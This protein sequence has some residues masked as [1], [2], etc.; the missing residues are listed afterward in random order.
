MRISWNWLRRYADT[1]LTPQQ[2][3]EVLTSTGLETE[4]VETFEPVKGMLEGVVVGHVLQ[5]DQHPDADRLSL[6]TV[7]LGEESSVQIVCGAPNVAAGQ[8]VLVATI[9]T[10]LHFKD[11]P[12]TIKKSKI[13]GQ[14]SHGMICAEDELGLGESH[15]GIMVLDPSAAIGTPAADHLGLKKDH[16]LEIGLTPNRTDAL[17]HIGVARDLIAA[18]N[19]RRG[20]S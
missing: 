2:A 20:L 17:G 19:H 11:G 13:R 14:E 15:E 12:I 3:A 5:R 1:D 7:D 8:K 10:T 6:C 18:L 16:V 4:G 9:G